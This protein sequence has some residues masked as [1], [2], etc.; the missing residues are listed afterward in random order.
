MYMLK[1]E[2]KQI[3]NRNIL[4]IKVQYKYI[5][6]R[7]GVENNSMNISASIYI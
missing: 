4:I 7:I 1:L 6:M 2:Y 3:N 5:I